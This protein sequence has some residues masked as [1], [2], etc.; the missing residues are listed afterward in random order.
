MSPRT[1]WSIAKDTVNELV[2]DDVLTLGAALAFYTALAMSPLL[3][4]F[5]WMAT[6]TGEGTRRQMIES[7]QGLVG[8]EGGAA[9]KAIIDNADA[10]PGFGTVAGMVSL[11]TLLFSVSG[12]FGQLQAALNRLWD[13]K[14][15]PGKAGWSVWIRK[16]VLSLGTVVC[17][18]FLL[19]VSLAVSALVSAATEHARG[20]L[21]GT[22]TVWQTITFVVS[23]AL[24]GLL[25]A[26]VFKVLPDVKLGWR[27][28]AAGGLATAILFSIGRFAIGLYL[29]RS[30]IGSAYGA[31]GSLIVLLVWVYYASLVVLAGAEL[32]QVMAKHFKPRIEPEEHAITVERT[33]EEVP[34]SSVRRA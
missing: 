21:P 1:A 27:D 11:V 22:E 10:T 23:L 18:G 19:V 7:M 30:S 28:V 16:R 9:V 33:E 14:A 2:E 17:V 13:V 32:T 3:M 25:F 20:M 29:G 34:P 8:P 24:S 4:L 31:A 15:I 5:I 12:V 6:F 26:L